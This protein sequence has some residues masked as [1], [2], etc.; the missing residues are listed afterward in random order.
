ME[1]FFYFIFVSRILNKPETLTG[2]LCM[3]V[4][5]YEAELTIFSQSVI[6][7]WWKLGHMAASTIGWC[8]LQWCRL[9]WVGTISHFVYKFDS[10]HVF[11]N[12][13]SLL[14]D[15]SSLGIF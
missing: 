5:I 10:V 2:E 9:H 4:N 13:F 7:Y 11:C 1:E 12:N 3:F 6:N 8:E 14:Y 15:K